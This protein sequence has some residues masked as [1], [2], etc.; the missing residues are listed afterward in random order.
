MR[1]RTL[2]STVVILIVDCVQFFYYVYHPIVQGRPCPLTI[3]ST[4]SDTGGSATVPSLLVTRYVLGRVSLGFWNFGY[5][6][7]SRFGNSAVN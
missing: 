2:N 4:L 6:F 3:T 1:S 7:V 5:V